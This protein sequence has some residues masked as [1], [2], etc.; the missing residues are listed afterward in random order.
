MSRLEFIFERPLLLLLAIP[1]FL[2]I[3]LPFFRLPAQRRRGFRKIAPVALHL[4]AVTLLLLVIAG[5]SVVN[6]SSEKAVMLLVDLSDS[7]QTV[8]KDIQGRA[9]QL[10]ELMDKKTPA[11]VVVFGQDQ[12]YTAQLSNDHTFST[13]KVDS[14]A[15]DI[16]AALE[17]TASLLPADRSGQIIVLS[18]GKQ[19]GGD[20]TDMAIQLAAQGI[21]IDAVY[22]DTTALDSDEVQ[23]S[24]LQAS[25]NVYKGDTITFTAQIQSNID[26]EA[27]LTL[28]ND[29]K[30]VYRETPRITAG[31]NTIEISCPAEVAG[32]HSY[33]LILDCSK[34]TLEQNNECFAYV[35]VVGEPSVLV[36]A[37]TL[38]NA[39]SL[40][41]LLGEE[42]SVKTASVWDA[43]RTV[44]ELCNY[45]A[46][47]LSNANMSMLPQD[48]DKLLEAYVNVYGR[49]LLTVGGESTLMYGGMQGTAM[50]DILPVTLSRQK[51]SDADSVALMLVMDCSGSMVQGGRNYLTLAK[52]GAIKCIK[53]MSSN[54]YVGVIT[55]NSVAQVQS[56]LVRATEN[57]KTNLTQII[58]GLGTGDYTFYRQ[59]LAFANDALLNCNAKTRHIMFLSDGHPSDRNYMEEV[60]RAAENDITVS[61]IS[62]GFSS[63]GL[64]SMAE[65]G[66][67]RYYNVKDPTELPKIMLS[68]TTQVAI[69]S[70]TLGDFTPVITRKSKL[71]DG[72]GTSR[73]PTLHGYLATTI[74]DDAHT[75]IAT[76][77]GHPIYAQ[78][79]YGKGVVG[80]FT[81]ALSGKWSYDWI[82]SR[83]GVAVTRNMLATTIDQLRG[84]SS[85]SAQ[86][87]GRGNTSEIK[88]TTADTQDSQLS[89]MVEMAGRITNYELTQEAPGI[90]TATFDTAKPGVYELLVTQAD[91]NGDPLDYWDTAITVSYLGE[92][93]VF[94][95]EGR[96]LLNTLCGYTGGKL[97][98]N[99]QELADVQVGSVQNS[100]NPMAV[101]ALLVSLIMLADI[102][103]RKLR[104]KDIR[105]FFLTLKR[106]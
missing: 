44:V 61:T 67:G 99:M 100:Y 7:T 98:T 76:E 77:E 34:D 69:D 5:F 30:L 86:V 37:D 4:V 31:T 97:Y 42:F 53:A 103:I 54:D 78:W 62:I 40:A 65:T 79:N 55:F 36:I 90:Y 9:A 46:V 28:L 84:S 60:K 11:G 95:A 18:D 91:R 12:I 71:T 2:I 73:L 50:E 74:K 6:H 75:Y 66:N 51:D 43:P 58:S 10:M 49:T 83:T 104:W 45:D 105:N 56:P 68:E 20:A 14:S 27:R 89:L 15:T 23:L 8:Q 47:V 39:K 13:A 26:T 29:S 24:S 57:N 82:S 81:S 3:L 96:T 17:Y 63:W 94:A 102:A 72:L 88:V 32:A 48:Y 16:A 64:N 92:Y 106:K 59:A 1:A 25:S 93:D 19:T 80:C 101:F 21:E 41:L 35:N 38:S 87:T 52:Q 70:L 33:Q 85:M 22:F